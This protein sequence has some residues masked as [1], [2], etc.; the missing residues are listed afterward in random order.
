MNFG[1][2]F[3]KGLCSST[4]SL[5]QSFLLSEVTEGIKAYPVKHQQINC[6]ISYT[7]E[8]PPPSHFLSQKV[9]FPR[10]TESSSAKILVEVASL[11]H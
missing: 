9:T 4:S 10:K 3:E 7:I 1:E 2:F 8:I 5:A 6:S 11:L